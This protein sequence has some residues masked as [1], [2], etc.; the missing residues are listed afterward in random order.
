METDSKVVPPVPGARG[1][2]KPRERVSN[3]VGGAAACRRRGQLSPPSEA[4]RSGETGSTPSPAAG[5][6]CAEGDE[7][8]GA[9]PV[10]EV[11]GGL[12]KEPQLHPRG[13]GESV[14]LSGSRWQ[15]HACASRFSWRLWR[16][17]EMLGANRGAAAMVGRG[18]EGRR[19]DTREQKPGGWGLESGSLCPIPPHGVW[20]PSQ[21]QAGGPGACTPASQPAPLPRLRLLPPPPAHSWRGG[22]L[23]HL[24]A[25]SR[26]TRT[27]CRSE[28][29]RHGLDVPMVI[30]TPEEVPWAGSVAPAKGP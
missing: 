28:V 3:P 11:P 6:G 21:H 17:G 8:A 1:P 23:P 19:G 13:G 16:G 12:V 14:R 18:P 30:A 10:P 9:W 5:A 4:A 26:S 2:R 24:T 20:G 22:F 29:F 7:A 25:L 15:C 27:F